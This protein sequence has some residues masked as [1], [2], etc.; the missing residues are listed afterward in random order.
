[1]GVR[2]KFPSDISEQ[3]AIAQMLADAD[4]EIATHECK[5]AKY[6]QLKS[7]MMS[8]LLTGNVRLG[9]GE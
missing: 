5:L 7:G 8:E 9:E 6:R 1:M 3:N 2:V 4:A